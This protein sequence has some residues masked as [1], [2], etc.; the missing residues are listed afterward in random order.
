MRRFASAAPAAS[1]VLLGAL[2]A[3]LVSLAGCSDGGAD[4]GGETRGA[5]LAEGKG[6][7]AGIVVDP[8][9]RPLADAQVSATPPGGEALHATTDLNGSFAFVGVSPGTYAVEATKERHLSA[10]AIAQVPEGGAGPLVHL[11]LEVQADELPFVIAVKWEGY[12]GCAF[13]YGNLCSVPAQGGA[14]A[15]GDQSA[16][17]FWDEYVG[18]ARIPDAVQGEAVWEATLA[19]SEQLQPIYGWSTPDE[20]RA[21]QYGGVFD[22]VSTA[23]PS[24]YRV[25][26]EDMLKVGLGTDVGLVVEFYSGD[27]SGLPAGL[28]INQPI[29]LFLHDFYGYEPPDA[30][31]FVTDG[32]PPPPT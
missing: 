30:W 25:P 18:Q 28:T 14:D 8:A 32:A 11:V 16:H 31:R 22:S 4:D 6:I 10:H 7:L 15:I 23:S 5:P 21:F 13:S 9:L 12:I 19:T 29:R 3:S 27:P 24:F 1:A 20:W 17:L 26:R 2:V